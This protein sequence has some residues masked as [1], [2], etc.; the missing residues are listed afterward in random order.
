MSD[1][2]LSGKFTLRIAGL[3]AT[4]TT[5]AAL[6]LAAPVAA[7]ADDAPEQIPAS[8][9]ADP[10]SADL[11]QSEEPAPDPGDGEPPVADDESEAN[12]EAL[13]DTPTRHGD[14]L[15]KGHI[16]DGDS[17]DGLGQAPVESQYAKVNIW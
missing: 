12:S 14:G 6:V 9:P 15:D 17:G 1:R 7:F 8:A 13:A 16:K 3:I 5:G 2:N 10:T 4:A 11:P